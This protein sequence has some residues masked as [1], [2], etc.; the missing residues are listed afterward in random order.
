MKTLE[1]LGVSP[2]PWRINDNAS[3]VDRYFEIISGQYGPYNWHNASLIAAAPQ[4]YKH[5]VEL[6][7]S[8]EDWMKKYPTSEFSTFGQAYQLLVEAIN[9]FRSALAK[10]AGEREIKE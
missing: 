9:N 3:V 8:L 4:M 6:V 1:Q 10:A 7:S 2:V 5:G